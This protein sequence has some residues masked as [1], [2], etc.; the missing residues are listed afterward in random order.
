[1]D[2][3]FHE[4]IMQKRPLCTVACLLVLLLLFAYALK[5]PPYVVSKTEKELSLF[6]D[7]SYEVTLTGTVSE[8]MA[9]DSYSTLLLS[10][11]KLKDK[12]QTFFVKN[13]RITF[14]DQVRYGIGSVV[15]VRGI[16]KETEDARNS[17]QFD[18]KL[19]NRIR[20]TGYQM[21]NPDVMV[22]DG[23]INP[24]R[25]FLSRFRETARSRILNVFP[26]DV[27][28]IVSAVLIGDK[29][30]MAD[31]QKERWQM[32]GISHMLVISGLHLT[33]LCVGLFNLLRRLH[34]GLIPSGLSSL[35]FLA[36][37][38][39][40]TGG[41]VSVFRAF[42]MT[43]LYVVAKMIGR[44]YDRWNAIALSAL[45][46]LIGNPWTLF[47]SGFQLSYAAVI[48]CA[49]FRKSSKLFISLILYFMT[50]PVL[51][52]SFYELPV[53]GIFLNLIFVPMLPLLL[54]TSFIGA[55]LGGIFSLPAV[56]LIHFFDGS[57]RVLTKYTS[58]TFILG[59]PEVWML[60]L[61][62]LL[63]FLFLL[64]YHHFRHEKRRL[65]LILLLPVLIGIFAIHLPDGLSVTFL[66]VGQGDG[67]VLQLP[68]GG[69][70]VI[71]GGSS[72]VKEVGAKRI[73]PYLKCSGIRKV[74]NLFI[75]HMDQDHINGLT[76]ILTAI[77]DGTTTL[78]IG[79]VALP[80]LATHGESYVTTVK[81]AKEAGVRILYLSEGDE[82]TL[83][84][85]HITVMNPDPENED[86]VE[87]DENAQ[88]LV[89]SVSYQNFDA[90]FTGDVSAEGEENILRQIKDKDKHYEVLK[91]AHHGSRFSTSEEF[92][93]QV[94]PSV[95]VISVGKGNFYGHPHAALLAR[96]R[97]SGC[98]I[99][100][101]Q[102]GGAVTIH[103]KGGGF[104]VETYIRQETDSV[105]QYLS[106]EN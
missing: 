55:V 100:K 23:S 78:K 63:I 83:D 86:P 84:G 24:F 73:L 64:L 2:I 58:S 71:D 12:T 106:N 29:S 104:T 79:T 36:F 60:L 6:L 35:L 59:K 13:I 1:M 66:D 72:T 68:K 20:N 103:T 77:R 95:S 33:L 40:F 85:V 80:Y 93:S 17:G 69:C 44:T 65:F 81:L 42:V 53:F 41:S 75:T 76:E 10:S 98:D 30:M 34:L 89:L 105:S 57:L 22:L 8:S 54:L 51:L 11:C 37:Y 32:G 19:Y 52:C 99:F 9:L 43:A 102:D 92:I 16:L 50:A 39:V 101:T 90:L 14:K 74:D 3:S 21:S 47:Y 48:T 18:S 4:A 70:A 61:Y 28:G 91:V 46:L 49:A 88:C 97:K 7:T 96:L 26:E 31:G 15:E 87:P 62:Y 94:R 67:I 56:Y 27:R 25:E 5:L 45:L 38:A 82:I